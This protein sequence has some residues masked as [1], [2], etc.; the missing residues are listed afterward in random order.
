MA[1]EACE[2]SSIMSG[3]RAKTRSAVG[4]RFGVRLLAAPHH[5][6]MDLGVTE[7]HQPAQ[8]DLLPAKRVPNP[9][10]SDDI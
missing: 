1:K 2:A 3:L 6:R 7:M 4:L 9:L 10:N 5:I 8:F